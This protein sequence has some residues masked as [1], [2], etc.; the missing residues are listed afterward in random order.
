MLDY[1]SYSWQLREEI[2]DFF[3]N[4]PTIESQKWIPCSERLPEA[5]QV[6]L[7]QDTEGTMWIWK[8]IGEDLEYRGPYQ[9]LDENGIWHLID[10]AVVWQPLPDPWKGDNNA[11]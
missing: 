4:A 3:D 10:E 1:Y 11:D 8:Y 7:I 5:E 9:W 6:V 2:G